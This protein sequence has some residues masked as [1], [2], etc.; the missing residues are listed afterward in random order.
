M[1]PISKSINIKEKQVK[2]LADKISKAKTLMIV[3]IKSLPSKQFQA[4]KKTIR[5]QASVL[6]AKKNIMIRSIKEVG[7]DSILPLEEHIKADCAFV[8][9]ELESYDLAGILAKKKTPAY[10]KAGQIALGEIEVKKGPTDLVPGPAISEL[11]SFG[12]QVAVENGKISIKAARVI[13]KEGDTITESMAS[14]LQ[15]LH[16]QPFTVGLE[17]KVAYDVQEEKIYRDIK[18][19]T[20]GYTQELRNAAGKALGFAQ[21]IVFYCK[22]TIGYFLAKANAE[23]NKLSEFAPKEEI[24][25][26]KVK[27]KEDISNATTD[28][29]SE[30]QESETTPSLSNATDTDIKE[31]DKKENA[32]LNSEESV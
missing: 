12:I 6:V 30:P 13:A 19:D 24:K 7:K 26:E 8:I 17:P 32:Q 20:E 29:E 27:A 3:S 16:I 18:I 15:K 10:A 21:K 31:K 4:I 5:E 25:E 23:G 11:G 28:K 22:E 1:I 2:D 14:L 9:S